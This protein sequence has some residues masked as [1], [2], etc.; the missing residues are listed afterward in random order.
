LAAVEKDFGCDGMTEQTDPVR[1]SFRGLPFVS[2][3]FDDGFLIAMVAV[4]RRAALH[5]T[6]DR[7]SETSYLTPEAG[8]AYLA[9]DGTRPLQ[10]PWLNAPELPPRRM[11]EVSR[12]L[13]SI[14]ARMPAWRPLLKLPVRCVIPAESAIVSGCEIYVPQTI[15]LGEQAFHS[16]EVL[17]ASLIHEL[18]HTW[19]GMICEISITDDGS[20]EWNFT[21]PSGTAQKSVRSVLFA[22]HFAISCGRYFG[23]DGRL[24]QSTLTYGDYARDCV[25][26]C[27]NDPTLTLM[28][29]YV[30]EE[31]NEYVEAAA[32]GG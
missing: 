13:L 17:E 16:P 4:K 24:I 21:L 10:A 22:A 30:W 8:A 12:A 7:Y 5:R 1:Q 2:D 9:T 14:S 31:L 19:L 25:G 27:R 18:A 15:A 6:N 23:T 28:G 32:M 11:A 3:D 26:L 20:G 29:R